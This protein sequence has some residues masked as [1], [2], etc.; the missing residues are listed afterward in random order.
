MD[1]CPILT[2]PDCPMR[3]RVIR[4]RLVEIKS[5]L[6]L[7]AEEVAGLSL[8]NEAKLP[9]KVNPP[10]TPSPPPATTP[11]PSLE[12][13]A[14]TA[15]SVAAAATPTPSTP[16]ASQ[17]IGK[18]CK[19]L[20]LSPIH[21]ERH[22][23]T[24]NSP[25]VLLST[26]EESAPSNL[27]QSRTTIPRRRRQQ[28]Q[29]QHQKLSFESG[30]KA[31]RQAALA[32][33]TASAAAGHLCPMRSATAA[34]VTKPRSQTE[35]QSS[36]PPS[37]T[38]SLI[39][40][41]ISPLLSPYLKARSS[42]NHPSLLKMP[43]PLKESGAQEDEEEE[44]ERAPRS[45]LHRL[46]PF[47]SAQ[48]HSKLI[49]RAHDQVAAHLPPV[50][51][52]APAP[53]AKLRPQQNGR[54]S[55]PPPLSSLSLTR[56]H[57]AT[58]LSPG[59]NANLTSKPNSPKLPISEET[60]AKV[61]GG[62]GVGGGGGDEEQE[63][64]DDIDKEAA[65]SIL[66]GRPSISPTKQ[67]SKFARKNDSQTVPHL[68]PI[69][70]LTRHRPITKLSSQVEVQP[71][72][73]PTPPPSPLSLS[74]TPKMPHLYPFNYANSKNKPIS[75]KLSLSTEEGNEHLRRHSWSRL[76]P[77]SR[78]KHSIKPTER[79][80]DQAATHLPPLQSTKGLKRGVANTVTAAAAADAATTTATAT[81][82][83]AIGS[84]II[85]ADAHVA[86]GDSV[87]VVAST[88]S[89]RK[90]EN[91]EPYLR[92]ANLTAPNHVS[93]ATP[94][95]SQVMISTKTK[96]TPRMAAASTAASHASKYSSPRTIM[97]TFGGSSNSPCLLPPLLSPV[98]NT[99]GA[100]ALT[101]QQQQQQQH[102]R[103]RR[104]RQRPP[105]SPP[106]PLPP[107]KL[108]R[109]SAQ[110]A[111]LVSEKCILKPRRRLRNAGCTG[112]F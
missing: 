32:V 80:N 4:E 31:T 109:E 70:S 28:Q 85:S 27:R 45:L 83:T 47:P 97:K 33:E 62:R 36:T 48:E 26:E 19:S 107:L 38:P 98:K 94:R 61:G 112:P 29:Q 101:Q 84:T 50:R 75:S 72:P 111:I 2:K 51:S 18:P 15:A 13:A 99:Q 49:R 21:H 11:P 66:V 73:T 95:L 22:T 24:A 39:R 41:T 43:I 7:K 60:E 103:G 82:A 8:V 69:P 110:N 104:H 91:E 56:P 96:P 25:K 88:M 76:A 1:K 58:Y 46:P 10:V 90:T 5:L 77:I 67:P 9:Y 42:T 63:E 30:R 57:N 105:S 17:A 108:Q 16:S 100:S 81:T 20:N 54:P 86:V 92:R 59:F 102:Q 44:E 65:R 14:A 3:N 55:T 93:P 40:P 79:A 12:A 53:T 68:S 74:V 6:R 35:V 52:P 78:L 34:S 23:S 37:L 106:S 71:T 89:S 64:D 87:D